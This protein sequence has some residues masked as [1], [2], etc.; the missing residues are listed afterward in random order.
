MVFLPW[1]FTALLFYN[2]GH[3]ATMLPPGGI[4]KELN[5]PKSMNTHLLKAATVSC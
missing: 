1:K 5:I 2:I 4:N 3:L